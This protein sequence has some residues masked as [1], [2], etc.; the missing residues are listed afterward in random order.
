LVGFLYDSPLLKQKLTNDH[1]E[2]WLLGRGATTPSPSF[3]YVYLNRVVRG[4]IGRFV[5]KTVDGCVHPAF[6]TATEKVVCDAVGG[7]KRE[8]PARHS[9]WAS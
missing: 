1:I 2:P 7:S 4:F 5:K 8:R 3:I 9:T 6:A